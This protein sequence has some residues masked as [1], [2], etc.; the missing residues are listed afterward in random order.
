MEKLDIKTGKRFLT[1]DGRE[2]LIIAHGLRSSIERGREAEMPHVGLIG[3]SDLWLF[4]KDGKIGPNAPEHACDLIEEIKPKLARKKPITLE[5]GK[6]YLTALGEV[7]E[8]LRGDLTVPHM[9]MPP[10]Q[11][12]GLISNE[13]PVRYHADGKQSVINLGFDLPD[14]DIA[15]EFVP[16]TPLMI[17]RAPTDNG[18]FVH[19][20]RFYPTSDDYRHLGMGGEWAT[21]IEDVNMLPDMTLEAANELMRKLG[22]S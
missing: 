15:E 20:A 1:R 4:T 2:C 11:F 5:V 9:M 13:R 16:R 14:D 10:G 21:V 19:S 18:S 22:A 6:R 3:H 17:T 12:L 7:V 8:I